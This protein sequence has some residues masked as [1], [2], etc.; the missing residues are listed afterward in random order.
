MVYES[1]LVISIL[2]TLVSYLCLYHES[3]VTYQVKI[4]IYKLLFSLH[5]VSIN[6]FE[7]LSKVKYLNKRLVF[8]SSKKKVQH[9]YIKHLNAFTKKII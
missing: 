2:K 9:T 1:Y 6:I 4:I 3:K 7:F 8:S 5:F